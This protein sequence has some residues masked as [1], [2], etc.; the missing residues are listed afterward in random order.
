MGEKLILFRP[1]F[2]R[3]IQV[4]SRPEHLTTDPGAVV[5][6]EVMERLGIIDWMT[7]RITDPRN[8]DL[9]THPTAELLRTAILLPA[10]GWR[11]QDDAD[12]LRHDPA[13]C[14][15]VS[16]RKGTSPLH[17][18]AKTAP[19]SKSQSRPVQ[20]THTRTGRPDGLPSQPTLSRLV[21]WLATPQNRQML[22]GALVEFASNWYA[23][24]TREKNFSR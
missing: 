6:R 24:A 2:N 21:S 13:L 17:T 15:A 12:T 9:V 1:S 14:L 19:E 16:A 10:Q 7:E 20:C 3:S 11:D 8:S 22:R 18:G 23:H 4:E 5:L